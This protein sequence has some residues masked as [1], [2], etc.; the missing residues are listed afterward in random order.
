[1]AEAKKTKVKLTRSAEDI[2]ARRKSDSEGF[3]MISPAPSAKPPVRDRAAEIS[4]Q[5]SILS[6]IT[7]PLSTAGSRLCQI[8]YGAAS[9]VKP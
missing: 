4:S 3:R 1:M 2:A 5:G 7:A 9:T 8:F 6:T